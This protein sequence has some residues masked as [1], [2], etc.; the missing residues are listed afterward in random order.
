MV[1]MVFLPTFIRYLGYRIVLLVWLT[2]IYILV[3]SLYILIT[4]TMFLLLIMNLLPIYYTV[5]DKN[6]F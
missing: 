6:I 4:S 2:L 5:F 1:N 3:I